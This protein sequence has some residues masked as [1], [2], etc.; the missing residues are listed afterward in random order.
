[1]ERYFQCGGCG[2]ASAQAATGTITITAQPG[3]ISTTAGSVS[4][5]ITVLA[6]SPMIDAHLPWYEATTDTNA[7]GTAIT[8]ATNRSFN[9]PIS[10][11]AGSY[12]YYCVI[13]S[14]SCASVKTQAVT[15]TVEAGTA[16]I[17]IA[18]SP[19]MRRSQK[20]DLR[21]LYVTAAATDGS[22]LSYQCY[23][24][25]PIAI[26]V[27]RWSAAPQR[28]SDPAHRSHGR[29]VLLL[30]VVSASGL[31]SVTSNP[32][33]VTVLAEGT[34]VITI[35]ANPGDRPSR[36]IPSMPGSRLCFRFGCFDTELPWYFE[37][38]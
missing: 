25:R 26:L 20:R 37:Q 14:E 10:L 4:G 32:A 21:K 30:C 18:R 12:Y 34:A 11:Q 9:L 28:H 24:I 8:G 36:S 16:T 3:S 5:A 29:H 17:H 22:T 23:G 33:T 38:R 2:V 1:L 15:V 35:T 13:S 27:A 6:T 31:T 19:M 7:S